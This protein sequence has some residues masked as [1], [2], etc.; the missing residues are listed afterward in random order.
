MN[1]LKVEGYFYFKTNKT[2]IEDAIDEFQNV[3]TSVGINA[4]NISFGVIRDE[5]GNDITDEVIY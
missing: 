1:E 3:C 2:N 5:N 4:D